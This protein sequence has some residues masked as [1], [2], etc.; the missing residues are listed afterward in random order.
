M[1]GYYWF[2]HI[3]ADGYYVRS[4]DGR[5]VGYR[6]RVLTKVP[7]RMPGRPRTRILPMPPVPMRDWPDRRYV[8]ED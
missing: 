3:D 6:Y 1:D 7:K 2:F 4:R 5:P 8:A